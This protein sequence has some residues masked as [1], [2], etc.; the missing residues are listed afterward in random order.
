MVAQRRPTAERSSS[1]GGLSR[2]REY[3]CSWVDV[4]G[5][6]AEVGDGGIVVPVLLAASG[7][8]VGLVPSLV[9]D[10]CCCCWE[11]ARPPRSIEGRT[12]FF[13]FEA[14]RI[15]SR[16][17]GTP[18]DTR[19]RRRIRDLTQFWGCS[20]GGAT[21]WDQRERERSVWKMAEVFWMGS[22]G[23]REEMFLEAGKRRSK[24]SSKTVLSSETDW[25]ASKSIRG[26]CTE[27]SIASTGRME[28]IGVDATYN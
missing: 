26:G 2:R 27:I 15:S 1:G 21:S 12:S 9:W 3:L 18:R 5:V 17:T 4:V 10:C 28:V 14:G 6:E 19:K 25:K 8:V 22:T 7:C 20:G 11:P 23:G 24:E 16:S 13:C